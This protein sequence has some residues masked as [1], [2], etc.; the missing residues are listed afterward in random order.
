M[1][2]WRTITFGA[3]TVALA[4]LNAATDFVTDA[5]LLSFIAGAIGVGTIILRVLTTTPVAEKE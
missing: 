5:K 4:A 1:K 3:I 2:G